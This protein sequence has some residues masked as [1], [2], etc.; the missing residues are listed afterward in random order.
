TRVNP[1]VAP[2]SPCESGT[3][4]GV[5]LHSKSLSTRKDRHTATRAP[6]GQAFGVNFWPA[7]TRATPWRTCSSVAS[8]GI[9]GNPGIG[10]SWPAAGGAEKSRRTNASTNILRLEDI[11]PPEEFGCQPTPSLPYVKSSAAASPTSRRNLVKMRWLT[12]H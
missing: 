3:G 5:R 9:G 10:C 6:L 12:F 11:A 1:V 2:Y 4:R 8:I 7:L